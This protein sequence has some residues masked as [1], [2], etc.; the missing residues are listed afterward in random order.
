[1]LCTKC[2]FNLATGKRT[3]AGKVVAAG[4]PQ[5][6]PWATPWYKTAYPYV[7]VVVVVLA[8]LF[9]LGRN[10]PDVKVVFFGVAALYV[11]TAHIIVAVAAFREGMGVGF[12]TLCIPFYAIYFVFKV[13]D[14]D[15]LKIVY[16][17]AILINIGLKFAQ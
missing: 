5:A 10:N 16:G 11:L 12:L 15:T 14:S 6:D 3:V 7:A 2:G 1:V 9:F 13:S 17:V 4:K 8:T